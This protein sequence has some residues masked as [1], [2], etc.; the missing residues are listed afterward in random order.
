MRCFWAASL[1]IFFL[2]FPNFEIFCPWVCIVLVMIT[3][4]C[5][6]ST[7]SSVGILSQSTLKIP[8]CRPLLCV[9]LP[10]WQLVLHSPT[11][12]ISS[13]RGPMPLT[14]LYL[15]PLVQSLAYLL[16]VKWIKA[17]LPGTEMVS[18]LTCHCFIME[19]WQTLQVLF[20]RVSV[21]SVG[22]WHSEVAYSFYCFQH[23]S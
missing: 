8:S 17:C 18:E 21:R 22:S 16:F 1:L 12:N 19:K 2:I 15:Q 5:T 10:T 6:L 13:R 7:Q 4:K 23:D 11:F 3:K 14:S 9:H 20:F